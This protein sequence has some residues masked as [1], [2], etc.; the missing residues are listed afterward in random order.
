MKELIF[1]M[2]SA[3]SIRVRAN[4]VSEMRNGDV[5]AELL[6]H[7]D[8]R[9]DMAMLDK[10]VGPM[11]WKREQRD[12]NMR[13]MCRVSIWDEE[14][15]EWIYKED[16]GVESNIA[17]EKGEVSDAFKRACTNWG[18]GRELY[19]APHIRIKLD[20]RYDYRKA[21]DKNGKITVTAVIGVSEIEC[22]ENRQIVKLVLRDGNNRERFVWMKKTNASLNEPIETPEGQEK[23][24]KVVKTPTITPAQEAVLEALVERFGKPGCKEAR[25]ALSSLLEQYGYSRTEELPKEEAQLIAQAIKTWG[26]LNP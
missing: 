21:D 22:D 8:A 3:D 2:L 4:R 6:L 17:K 10:Y 20:G 18:I 24:A 14:K 7:K 5:Y 1:P 19:T 26:R 13:L 25:D 9:I 15:Q 23:I 11:N 12:I 16:V